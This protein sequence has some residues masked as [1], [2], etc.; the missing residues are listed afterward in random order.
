MNNSI[1]GNNISLIDD[2]I[3]V[4]GET[5]YKGDDAEC[6]FWSV[7]YDLVQLC[8]KACDEVIKQWIA[9]QQ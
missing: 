6:K 4:N 5:V 9:K 2:E 1:L 8:G 7:Y 3:R